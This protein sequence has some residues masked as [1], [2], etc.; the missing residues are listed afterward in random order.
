MKWSVQDRA[1]IVGLYYEC[2][3][4]TVAAQRA[5]R[6]EKQVREAPESHSV[7][8]WVEQFREEGHVLS[9]EHRAHPFIRQTPANVTA[10]ARAVKS[11]PSW[12]IRQLSNHTGISRPTVQRILRKKLKLFPYKLQVTQRILRGD[13]AKRKRFCRWFLR[14]VQTNPRFI[15]LLIMSDEAVFTLD[16]CVLKHNSRIWSDENPHAAIQRSE[17]SPSLTVWC[18]VCSRGV[19]GPYF[20]EEG[21]GPVTVNGPRY[22]HMLQHWFLPALEREGISVDHAWFQQDGATSHTAWATLD[23][24]AETFGSRVISKDFDEIWPPRS[25]DLTACDFFLWG[26]LKN[27][28]YAKRPQPQSL[29]ELKRRIRKA[30]ND[31]PVNMVKKSMEAVIYRCRECSCQQGSH[32]D[33]VIFKTN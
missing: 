29:A 22:R 3:R 31:I 19:V 5:F 23:L 6:R 14:K 17:F 15:N 8:R 4:S 21:G 1:K 32:L 7:E 24:L 18:A 30:V 13:K 9:Q 10:V 20:F 26:Y 16:G 27:A 11:H 12:S 25:P 28:V 33:N 2:G